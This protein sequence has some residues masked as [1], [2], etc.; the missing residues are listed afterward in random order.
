MGRGDRV[1]E[2]GPL[3]EEPLPAPGLGAEPVEVG[4]ARREGAVFVCVL[5]EVVFPVAPPTCPVLGI[6]PP[7]FGRR[8]PVLAPPPGIALGAVTPLVV[9]RGIV[10][11]PPPPSNAGFPADPYLAIR[12]MTPTIYLGNSGVKDP[13]LSRPIMIDGPGRCFWEH[14]LS[15]VEEADWSFCPAPLWTGRLL[16]CILTQTPEMG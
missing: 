16:P 9:G 14:L 5:P 15:W 12:D 8:D 11:P 6:L 3:G 13:S 10:P 1:R 4:G 7:P 2:A